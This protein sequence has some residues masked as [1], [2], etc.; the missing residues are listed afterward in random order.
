MKEWKSLNSNQLESINKIP[1][2]EWDKSTLT[3]Y[4]HATSSICE[5]ELRMNVI[6]VICSERRINNPS[7]RT[8]LVHLALLESTRHY[9]DYSDHIHSMHSSVN[10]S[11]IQTVM[12]INIYKLDFVEEIEN[13]HWL[14]LIS[15]SSW[16]CE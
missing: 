5:Y 8:H 6:R 11:T 16:L 14:R 13:H 7:H 10:F 2:S 12:P 9:S 1:S 4:F 3:P 15:D